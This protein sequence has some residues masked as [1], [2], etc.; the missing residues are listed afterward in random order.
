MIKPH[1]EI[2]R[3]GSLLVSQHIQNTTNEMNKNIDI[4]NEDKKFNITTVVTSRSTEIYMIL[5]STP[6]LQ[7]PRGVL[8]KSYLV[9]S[10]RSH[11]KTP[12]MES[13]S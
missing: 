12:A 4:L 1:S 2:N 5:S 10:Y 9:N 6:Y 3:L 13:L 7:S 11:R 8:L